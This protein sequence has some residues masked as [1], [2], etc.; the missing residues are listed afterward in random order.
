M[1]HDLIIK[2]RNKNWSGAD[3]SKNIAAPAA[4]KAATSTQI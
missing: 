1:I 2:R 3:P 4:K